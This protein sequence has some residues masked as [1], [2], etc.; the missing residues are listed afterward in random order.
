MLGE[1]TWQSIMVASEG[2]A[3]PRQTVDSIAV[4][5]GELKGHRSSG[6]HHVQGTFVLLPAGTLDRGTRKQDGVGE[7]ECALQHH[8]HT[9]AQKRQAD[10]PFLPSPE[11]SG[12]SGRSKVRGRRA[13]SML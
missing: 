6:A 8:S 7:V 2:P 11:G 4:G 1:R 13:V 5:R 12:P 9:G 10:R 3:R